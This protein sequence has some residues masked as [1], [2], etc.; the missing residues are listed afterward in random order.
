MS[1]RIYFIKAAPYLIGIGIPVA[2]ALASV[3]VPVV[4][5]QAK[6]IAKLQEAA[7]NIKDGISKIQQAQLN[8][9]V[10]LRNI[11]NQIG[12]YETPETATLAN[13]TLSVDQL[14][15]LAGH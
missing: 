8:A 15:P 4:F 5:E 13:E 11:E 2:I 3:G 7:D 6:D 9:A 10:S 1:L 14:E 12:G